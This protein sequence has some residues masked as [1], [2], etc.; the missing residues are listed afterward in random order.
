[1]RIYSYVGNYL[2]SSQYAF[3]DPLFFKHYILLEM[4]GAKCGLDCHIPN[5][6]NS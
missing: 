3:I 4:I 1:M 5:R 6:I 2:Y